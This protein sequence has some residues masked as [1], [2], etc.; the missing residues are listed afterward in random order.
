MTRKGQKMTKNNTDKAKEWLKIFLNRNHSAYMNG[1][2]AAEAAGYSGSKRQWGAIATINKKK[3]A[4][5]IEEYREKIK[6]QKT[7]IR[8]EDIQKIA[9]DLLFANSYNKTD[10]GEPIP[11]NQ[12]R[13]K[14]LALLMK[15]NGLDENFLL[16]EDG[17]PIGALNVQIDH[18]Q[19]VQCYNIDDLII[20]ITRFLR[21]QMA[22][23]TD[24]ASL[25]NRLIEVINRINE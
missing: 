12:T 20:S 19:A 24:I 11:D 23:G 21:L 14:V 22:D 1:T 2:E 5:E 7:T 16:G 25:K 15:N 3:Y 17:N 10:N 6:N 13:A 9:H 4:K 8:P 18:I